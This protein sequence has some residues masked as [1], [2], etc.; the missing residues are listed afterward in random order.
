MAKIVIFAPQA[1][2]KADMEALE[3][4]G[5]VPIDYA[6]LRSIFSDYKFP[7]NKIASLENDGKIIRLKKGLYVV[8]PKISKVLLSQELIANHLYGPSYVSMESALRYY[9]LIP[10]QVFTVSS[11]T[12]NRSKIFKNEIATFRYTSFN[13][14]YYSVGIHQKI[15]ENRYTFLI[16]S[17]EKALCDL[18]ISTPH[19]NFQSVKAIATYLEEDIRFDISALKEMDKTI[20]EECIAQGKKKKSLNLLLR[21]LSR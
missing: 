14:E 21:L 1:I 6:V 17:P 3:Q 19:L 12:M 15:V 4:L 11:A 13:E 9:G 10:E 18:I 16:A 5:V 7:K 20:I 8:S 2:P